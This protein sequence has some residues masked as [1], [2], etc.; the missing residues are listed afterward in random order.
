MHTSVLIIHS[1]YCTLL[2][3]YLYNYC[4]IQSPTGLSPRTRLQWRRG[5]DAPEVFRESQAVVMGERVYVGGDYKVFQYDWR[6]DTWSTLPDCPVKWF[7]MAQF[8][9]KLITV[10]GRD[11][12]RSVTGKV[13]QFNG[14]RREEFLPPMITARSSLTVVTKTSSSP[15]PPAIVACGGYGAHGQRVDTVEVYSHASSQWHTAKPL[16]IPCYAITSVTIDDT[17]YLLGGFDS[18]RS[19]TK[20]CFSVSLNSLIDNATSPHSQLDDPIWMSVSDT[21]LTWSSAASLRGSLIAIG[22][23]DTIT[24]T[25]S[26]ALHVLTSD[27]SWERVRGGDLPEP[28]LRSVAVCLPSGELLVAGGYGDSELKK[29]VFIVD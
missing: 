27:G 4:S 10:G 14:Q 13:C 1:N 29:T 26:S 2:G 21:P 25:T 17:C 28:R 18:T 16:P 3:G 12:Q 23:D 22:G 11:R 24:D 8:L 9:G 19:G 20:C 7:G 6:R 5:A 15:K